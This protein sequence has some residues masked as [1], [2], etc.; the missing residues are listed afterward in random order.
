MLSIYTGVLY[1]KTYFLLLRG[2]HSPPPGRLEIHY[3]LLVPLCYL[4]TMYIDST[5]DALRRGSRGREEKQIL[6]YVI[7]LQRAMYDGLKQ[8]VVSLK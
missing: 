2:Q 3:P 6:V 4:M 5:Q 8:Y 7:A 1:N